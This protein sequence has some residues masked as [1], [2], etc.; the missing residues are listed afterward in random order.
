MAMPTQEPQSTAKE[1]I[2]SPVKNEREKANRVA[3]KAAERAGNTEH[4]YD[5][6]NDIF[7]K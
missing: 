2:K 1:D 6:S 4:G 7:T 5:S 3:E